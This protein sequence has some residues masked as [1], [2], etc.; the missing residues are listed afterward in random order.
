MISDSLLNLAVDTALN[1]GAA[2]NYVVGNQVDLGVAANGIGANVGLAQLFLVITMTTAATSG[3]AAT[4]QFSLL[5]DGDSAMGTPNV[6]ASTGAIALASLTAGAVVGIIALPVGF[7]L[8]RYIGLRQTTGVAAFTGGT[9]DA[10]I[11]STPPVRYA[12]PQASVISY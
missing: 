4:V 3:G 7:S 6:V 10:V 11:T 2:G 9:F 8:E 12:Y 1:T 5:S